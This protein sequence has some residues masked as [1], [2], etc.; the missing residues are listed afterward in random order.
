ME[1]LSGRNKIESYGQKL[2]HNL[3]QNMLIYYMFFCIFYKFIRA[4]LPIYHST[5]YNY[6][7]VSIIYIIFLISFSF[8]FKTS[9][10]IWYLFFIYLIVSLVL[11]LDMLNFQ[12]FSIAPIVYSIKKFKDMFLT[13]DNINLFTKKEYI[14]FFADIMIFV[15]ACTL[16]KKHNQYKKNIKSFYILV[17][18]SVVLIA[19]IKVIPV[20]ELKVHYIDVG[21]GDSIFIEY[22][23]YQIL[24]DG[25]YK[26]KSAIIVDYIKKLNVDDID[27]LIST[28]AHGDHIGGLIEVLDKF[29]VKTIID[30]GKP[31]DSD[32][33]RDYWRSVQKKVQIEGTKYLEDDN[34]SFEIDRDIIFSIIETGDNYDETNDL[35]VVSKLS[36]K[37][38]GFLFTGDIGRGVE[39]KLLSKDI[40][41]DVLKVAHHGSDTSSTISFLNKV[42]PSYAVVS[43][44]KNPYDNPG[45]EIFKKLN[46]TGIKSYR[47]DKT[48]T[49]V[50][51]TDGNNIALNKNIGE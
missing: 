50:V 7:F 37:N 20:K 51:S 14:L 40:R 1:L 11:L 35:S 30:S 38:V 26:D 46:N 47:T 49:I 13:I 23:D 31:F 33:Y 41:A 48:G 42:K 12:M 17:I 2:V 10:R 9:I 4:S 29:N 22:G 15:V 45:Q 5:P 6:I 25:G 21:Y 27:I 34:I 43:V 18:I 32:D 36:Y 39:D 24:I 44:G 19:T 3:N 28:H 8:L 16:E